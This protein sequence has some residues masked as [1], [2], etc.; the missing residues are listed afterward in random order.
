MAPLD[1]PERKGNG[2]P[3]K[4]PVYMIHTS[5]KIE[6]GTEGK[7][8][9]LSNHRGASLANGKFSP[10]VLKGERDEKST[11]MSS[12]RTVASMRHTYSRKNSSRE[13]IGEH[14][15]PMTQQKSDGAEGA[16]ETEDRPEMEEANVFTNGKGLR[17][18]RGFYELN[19]LGRWEKM[20][21]PRGRESYAALRHFYLQNFTFF[22]SMHD[23]NGSY[24][25]FRG[26]LLASV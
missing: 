23:F 14:V 18:K 1:S 4:A 16:E 24:F 13:Q 19:A 2:T 8:D 7:A 9:P 22:S 20:V 11:M 17:K 6:N 5:A 3:Q 12:D 26:N 21:V 10:R 15:N 25:N